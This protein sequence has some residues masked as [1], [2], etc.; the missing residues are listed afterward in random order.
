MRK[1][2]RLLSLA[3][4][5]VFVLA[6]PA[7]A[8]S[9]DTGVPYSSDYFV[10]NGAYLYQPTAGSLTFEV[11]FETVAFGVMAELGST[12]IRVER[13]ENGVN[14][15]TTVKTYTPAKYPQMMSQNRCSYTAS[16]SYTGTA[17][18]YYRAYVEFYAKNNSGSGYKY[19]YAE[20]LGL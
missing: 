1:S 4:V 15:W 5:L 7:Q 13:S 20:P 2:A 19:L 11:W 12:S 18:Y 14:G 6:L 17:G 8:V 10:T 16:V 3:L 9:P